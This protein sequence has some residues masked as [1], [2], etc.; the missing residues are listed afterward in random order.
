MEKL[1]NLSLLNTTATGAMVTMETEWLI[2]I[3]L[4][5]KHGSGQKNYFFTS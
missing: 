5:K 1:K 2:P 3:Q 4:V